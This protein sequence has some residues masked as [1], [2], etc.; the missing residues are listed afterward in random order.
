LSK[1]Y[2]VFVCD[3]YDKELIAS[4]IYADTFFKVPQISDNNYYSYML[5]LMYYNKI[6]IIIP[7]IDMD[8]HYFYKDN[9]DLEKMNIISTGPSKYSLNKLSN[10]KH[11]YEYCRRIG[12]P[13]P[14]EYKIE[15]IHPEKEYF[16]KPIDGF[17]SKGAKKIMGKN[18]LEDITLQK[19]HIIQEVC[20]KPEVT[21]EIFYKNKNNYSHIIRERLETKEGVCTKAKFIQDENLENILNI[22]YENFD[23]P[24]TSCIQFMKKKNK[25]VLTDF[26]LRLGA[27]TALSTAIG[28]DLTYAFLIDLLNIDNPFNYLKKPTSPKIVVRVYQEII[29]K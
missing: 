4:S 19:D 27:G 21:V 18:I 23:L 7:L 26:N 15:E 6:D 24:Q 17:G 28:W 9:P 8:L 11:V 22:I 29:M 13:V 12:I 25:W 3:I 20:D 1:Y 14:Q 2:E 10:K 5:E 16:I